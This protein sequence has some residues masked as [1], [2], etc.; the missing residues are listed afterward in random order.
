MAVSAANIEESNANKIYI[1]KK[2]LNKIYNYY[3]LKNI[4]KIA[5]YYNFL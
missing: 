1:N 5:I 4:I 2:S 3:I